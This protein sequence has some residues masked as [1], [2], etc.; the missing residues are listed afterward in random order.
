ME[1]RIKS[2]ELR[3]AY[4]WDC[5]HCGRENFVNGLVPELSPEDLAFLKNDHGVEEWDL[6]Q[7]VCMP[8]NVVCPHCN[9]QFGTVHALD[10]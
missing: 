8:E 3:A 1:S 9:A 5:E 10:T 2:V 7:F 4:A 6:G